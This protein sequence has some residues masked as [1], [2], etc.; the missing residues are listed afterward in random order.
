MAQKLSEELRT[1]VAAEPPGVRGDEQETKDR[2]VE[3]GFGGAVCIC[4]QEQQ[5]TRLW[6]VWS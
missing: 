1:E 6:C 4:I 5:K 2:V 3:R